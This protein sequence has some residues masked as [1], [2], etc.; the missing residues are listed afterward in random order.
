MYKHNNFNILRDNICNLGLD[1]KNII[2]NEVDDLPDL[3]VIYLQKSV[4]L[5]LEKEQELKT[6]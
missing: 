6:S 3:N 1:Y 2:D 4:F 5:N